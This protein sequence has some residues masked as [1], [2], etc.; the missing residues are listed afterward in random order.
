MIIYPDHSVLPGLGFTVKWSPMFY[1]MPTAVAASG[2]NIDLGLAQYPLHDFELAYEFLHDWSD[3]S[4]SEAEEF[5]T[6]MGFHLLIGGTLGRFAFKNPDDYSVKQQLIGV[7][8]NVTTTFTLIRSYGARGYVASEPVGVVDLTQDFNVYIGDSASPLLPT[9]YTVNTLN[10]LVQ[11]ITLASAPVANLNVRVDMSYFYYCKLSDNNL[12]FE[13][14][15]HKLWLLNS[16]KL[17]SCR[18]GE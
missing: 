5:K 7:G 9:A 16:I 13:K 6:L 12:T 3:R 14:F 8:D 4:S 1:N 11:T 17:H 2:A 18:P 15:M 10:P